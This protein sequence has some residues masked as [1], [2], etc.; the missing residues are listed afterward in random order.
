MKY[1]FTTLAIGEPYESRTIEFFK[2]LSEKTKKCDFFMTT[3]N[4]NLSVLGDK[5]KVNLIIQDELHDSRGGFSFN[6]N[7]KCLSLKHV[8]N[9]EKQMIQQNPEF[10]TYDYIIFIDGDWIMFDE[11]SEEKII[12]MLNYMDSENIDFAFE[13]PARIGDGRLNPEQSFYRDKIYDYEI[14]EYDKWDDAHVVNEQFLVFKNNYKFKLFVNRWEQFLWF[15]IKN[16]IRNY[17]D[18]FEIGVSALESGMKWSY[19]GV[20]T[21]FLTNCFAFY[22]KNNVFHVRF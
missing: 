4:S 1:C 20:F 2:N 15:T 9:Y 14:L 6:L 21:H 10:E 22:T 19:S 7:L 12:N 13:R 18:G 8:K 5:I 16:D 17:P 11:F 3:N